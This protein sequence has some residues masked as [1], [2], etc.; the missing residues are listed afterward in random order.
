MIEYIHY[1]NKS[2]KD[3][4]VQKH[5]PEGGPEAINKLMH[6]HITIFYHRGAVRG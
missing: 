2:K 5:V 6:L 1:L 3:M 4:Q